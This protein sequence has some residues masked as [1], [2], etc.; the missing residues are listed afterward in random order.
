M[1][2]AWLQT[3][4][5]PPC[6]LCAVGEPTTWRIA[7]ATVLAARPRVEFAQCRRCGS[8]FDPGFSQV[9]VPLPRRMLE[10]YLEQGAGIEVMV[11]PL[12]RVPRESVRS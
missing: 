9:E 3:G 1:Q 12:L 11:A 7:A 8:L 4:A 2:V 6:P 5:A 10:Y